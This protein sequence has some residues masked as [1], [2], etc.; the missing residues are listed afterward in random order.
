VLCAGAKIGS[1]EARMDLGAV[2]VTERGLLGAG[3]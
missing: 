2:S 1:A 3:Q